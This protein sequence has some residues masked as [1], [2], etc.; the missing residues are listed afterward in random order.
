MRPRRVLAE[1]DALDGRTGTRAGA[2]NAAPA[3]ANTLQERIHEWR[4]KSRPGSTPAG[5][6]PSPEGGSAQGAGDMDMDGDGDG[7]GDGNGN[8]NGRL[9]ALVPGIEDAPFRAA[10]EARRQRSDG[11]SSPGKDFTW[12]V[13][14]DF[15]AGDVQVSDSPRIR[16]GA[17]TNKPFANRPSIVPVHDTAVAGS[18]TGRLRS[19]ARSNTRISDIQEDEARHGVD[20]TAVGGS[21]SGSNNAGL[22]NLA[23]LR[24]QRQR[25]EKLDSI[26]QLESAGLPK[27][28]LAAMRL[29]EIKEQNAMARTRRSEEDKEKEEQESTQPKRATGGTAADAGAGAGAGALTAPPAH[30]ISASEAVVGRTGGERVADSPVTIYKSYGGRGGQER[31]REREKEQEKEKEKAVKKQDV[32]RERDLLRR[33]ARAASASPAPAPASASAPASAPAPAAGPAETKA[34]ATT[35]TATTRSSKRATGL[36]ER[37]AKATTARP[38]LAGRFTGLGQKSAALTSSG[39]MPSSNPETET[40]TKDTSKLGS[41]P[42]PS[43]VNA[44]S[45]ALV[46]PP[47]NNGN[48]NS[49]SSSSSSN[50]NKSKSTSTSSRRRQ[51][52]RPTVGF[53]G[54]RREHSAESAKSKQSASMNSETDPTARIEAEMNL[55]APA[56][57]HSEPGSGSVRAPSIGSDSDDDEEEAAQHEGEKDGD[58]I[59]DDD[60]DD[61]NLAEATPKPHKHDLFSMPTPRVTGAYVETPVT[62]KPVRIGGADL[63]QAVRPFGERLGQARRRRHG[64]DNRLQEEPGED[65][66]ASDPGTSS[67][68]VRI[69]DEDEGD[70]AVKKRK[71][72]ARARARSE[73]RRRLPL[74]LRNS[75]R[76]PSV[77]DDLRELQ[78]RHNI[79][80]STVDDFQDLLTG[81]KLALPELA[82]GGTALEQRPLS[83]SGADDGVVKREL[84]AVDV[85]GDGGGAGAEEEPS[86]ASEGQST[87]VEKMGRTVRSGLC[88]IREAK[89]GIE[90]LEG[91]LAQQ[92]E[93]QEQ[94]EQQQQKAKAKVKVKTED[95]DQ[96]PI[97]AADSK[98]TTTPT[99]TSTTATGIVA[100]PR[101]H[102]TQRR[103]LLQL[104]LVLAAAFL[105]YG[106]L[107]SLTCWRFCRPSTCDPT[108]PCV[109]S[110]DDPTRLGTALPVKLDQWLTGGRGRSTAH[111][112]LEEGLD[113]MADV[114]DWAAGR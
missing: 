34:K 4:T 103:W 5:G 85:D 42:N 11:G 107:E 66:T 55:F 75:A 102:L 83:L 77:K 69:R 25:N 62:V 35:A 47:E 67:T 100:T 21:S 50:S 14:E 91:R 114:Q 31:E 95:E 59:D 45:S 2:W 18:P 76:P 81:Q 110:Y 38:S 105:T 57:N 8:G 113:R 17:N 87:L 46:R 1:D 40:K 90:R 98:P 82:L 27:R 32:A 65:D 92:Q 52:P 70:A 43:G 13:D 22:T 29:A 56:D 73:P 9:P 68:R 37:S 63:A 3:A 108:T 64:E 79:D 94:Q 101:K 106:A 16:V 58:Y 19:P 104:V 7:D 23:K 10:A 15:T 33:L 111:W 54:L 93:Q 61:D 24:Q 20:N 109:Y 28:V 86:E 60:D 30:P 96:W 97:C 89:M 44:G 74:P 112:M 49:S 36:P 53:A 12:Q 41:K 99:P 71:P 51:L 80:D 72:R 6:G 84:G 48:R 78:R 39:F 88:N 26:R